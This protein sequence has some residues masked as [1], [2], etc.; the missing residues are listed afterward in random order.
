MLLGS[1]GGHMMSQDERQIE[2]DGSA[3]LQ[4]FQLLQRREEW[5]R[6]RSKENKARQTFRAGTLGIIFTTSSALNGYQQ[7]ALANST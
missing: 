6:R 3:G 5:G 7:S 4:A 2:F 1:F